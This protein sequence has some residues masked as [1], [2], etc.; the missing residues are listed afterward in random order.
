[1]GVA[2]AHARPGNSQ[3]ERVRRQG[4]GDIDLCSRVVVQGYQEV[5]DD[6]VPAAP[7]WTPS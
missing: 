6:A 2:P 1:M 3:F 5:L 4:D 7:V